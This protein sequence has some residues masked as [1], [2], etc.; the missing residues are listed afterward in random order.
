MVQVRTCLAA[1]TSPTVVTSPIV[2]TSPA[3]VT[4]RYHYG[5]IV[6]LHLNTYNLLPIEMQ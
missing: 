5:F 3:A 6:V 1:V 2:V 4:S